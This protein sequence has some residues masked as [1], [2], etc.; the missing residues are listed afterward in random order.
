MALPAKKQF[1]FWGIFVLVSALMLWALGHVLLPFVLGGAI[2]YFLDPV[3][4]RLE[5]SGLSRA[6]A[7]ALITL[8]GLLVFAVL[9]LAVVPTLIQQFIALVETLPEVVQQV[10]AFVAA[11]FPSMQQPDSVMHQTL[12]QLG[13]V[14][15]ERGGAFL[16][17]ALSS[18][19]SVL[20]VVTLLVIAPVVAFY[21]LLDWDRMVAEVDG[22]LPRDHAP[23]IRRLASD[24]DKT[25]A[26]FV[27]GMGTV[28][29]IL[30]TYYAVALMVVGLQFG[31]VVGSI[32]GLVTFIPYLGALIGGALAIGL[33]LFQFWGDWLQVGLVGIIFAIGQVVEGN[34]L[35]PKLV[36]K[37]VG[38]HPVW[39]LLALSVFGALFG[40]VGML[41]AVPVAA[42][43]GVLARFATGQYMSSK[44]Y[45]GHSASQSESAQDAE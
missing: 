43:I 33:A 25:L 30:G 34:I 20:N 6:A 12:Q 23:I 13:A 45:Y 37:S 31:L 7:T 2:A 36:G 17:T 39:L 22:L 19:M 1:Q 24:I 15:K 3:A 14:L 38:L 18:A 21:L 28:C 32:A 35:T 41:V 29:L 11:K 26:S 10:R 9:V 4:D 16:Q 42:A 8:V 27:R 5:N 40:F 44:L